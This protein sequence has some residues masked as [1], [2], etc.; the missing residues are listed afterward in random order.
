[1]NLKVILI[2]LQVKNLA[3]KHLSD[4][5]IHYA[6]QPYHMSL[7]ALIKKIITILMSMGMVI[8]FYYFIAEF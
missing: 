3:N 7:P 1:M 8:M 2:L 5:E 4:Y 6:G